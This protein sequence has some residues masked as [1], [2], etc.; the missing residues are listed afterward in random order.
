MTLLP[1]LPPFHASQHACQHLPSVVNENI[2]KFTE[3]RKD[4]HSAK[5]RQ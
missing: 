3:T 1:E 4:K 5:E 2:K